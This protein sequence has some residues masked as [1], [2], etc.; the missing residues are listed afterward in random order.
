MLYDF[1]MNVPSISAYF[2][3]VSV[4]AFR[5]SLMNDAHKFAFQLMVADDELIFEIEI[6]ETLLQEGAMSELF[7]IAEHPNEFET[8]TE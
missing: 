5:L 1:E 6:P 8:E 2:Q 7:F 3:I 4:V